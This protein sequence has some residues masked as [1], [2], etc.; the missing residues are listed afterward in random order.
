MLEID[1]SYGSGGGQVLRTALGISALTGKA[2]RITGIRAKRPDP[3][4][5]AQ[6]LTGLNTIARV[7]SAEV[8]GAKLRSTAVT[9]KPKKPAPTKLAVNI[10]TAGSITLLLQTL[11]LPALLAELR[12][13]ITGGTDVA[14]SPSIAYMQRVLLPTLKGMGA[15]YEAGLITRGYYPKGNGV[16]SFSS[17]KAKLPL[18]PLAINEPGKLQHILLQSHSA[19]LPREVA[20]N[21]ASAARTELSYGPQ[22]SG[23]EIEEKISSETE[24][25]TIGCGLD[26]VAKF[27]HT[28]MAANSL[29]KKGKPALEVGREAAQKLL[30]ELNSGAAVDG[31]LADQLIP[32]MA[33]ADGFSEFTC[34]SLSEHTLTNIFVTEKMLGVRFKVDGEKG[35]KAKVGV[36]GIGLS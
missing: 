27:E 5:K 30:K 28:V 7:C 9:F 33:I 36:D 25:N 26:L 18:R 12:L 14:W 24:R 11:F 6:H 32:F 31:H 22:A 16:V 29:G 17:R 3:G 34:S 2:V 21:T 19:S 4:L 23:I 15:N 35:K 8:N 20:L 10:G 13:R 1:G